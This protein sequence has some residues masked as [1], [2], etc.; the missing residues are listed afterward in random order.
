[1]KKRMVSLFIFLLMITI[2]FNLYATETDII[3]ETEILDEIDPVDVN[4]TV[5]PE[6]TPKNTETMNRYT[7]CMF[8]VAGVNGLYLLYQIG[9][10]TKLLSILLGTAG[11]VGASVILMSLV[12]YMK[13][14]D[15]TLNRQAI[16]S[17]A[18]GIC[19]YMAYFMV[20]HLE[21]TKNKSED[22]SWKKVFKH[23]VKIGAKQLLGMMNLIFC[24]CVGIAFLF[25][26]ANIVTKEMIGISICTSLGVVFTIIL[27]T[28]FY[29][30]FN[31]K[32]TIYKTIS[33]NKLEGKRSLKL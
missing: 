27:S 10:N 26:N 5:E 11:G 23:G 22:S 31:S 28:F 24:G 30:I 6:V 12:N 33:E 25:T 32:K 17:V 1:M 2:C 18:F 8:V 3:P 21:D 16:A 7:I 19:L 13:K 4:F 20:T 9:F 29:G 14:L 15:L